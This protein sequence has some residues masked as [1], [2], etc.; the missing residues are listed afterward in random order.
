MITVR[1]YNKQKYITKDISYISVFYDYDDDN[2]L[3]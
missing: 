3:S 1:Y 2:L